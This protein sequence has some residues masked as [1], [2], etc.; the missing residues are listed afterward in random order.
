MRMNTEAFALYL[1]AGA[2]LPTPPTGFIETSEKVFVT[3]NVTTI[4]SKRFNGTLSTN[5]TDVDTC[6]TTVEGLAIPH[7]MRYQNS[8]G[9]ALDTIPDYSEML[10]LGGFAEVVDTTTAGEETVTYNWD[11]SKS[12]SLGSAVYYID[13]YK[14]TFTNTL[15]GNTSFTFNIGEV[16]MINF[17]MS[18]FL[19]NKGI[20]VAEANPATTLSDEGSLFVGCA[21]IYTEDGTRINTKS[22]SIDMGADIGKFYGMGVKEYQLTM[23]KPTI[24]AEFYLEKDDYNKAMTRLVDQETFDVVIKLGTVNGA[25]VNGKTVTFT[26][27]N[28]KMSTFSDADDTNAIS[29]THNLILT[30]NSSFS[31]FHGFY[32]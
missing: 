21:D 27:S 9:D 24:T 16:A 26:I 2:T 4:D 3:P 1:S 18:G 22:I 14:Q 25:D 28:V 5:D 6:N 11:T 17:A 13:G 8:A 19:D 23:F 29:R 7:K 31:I 32:S 20:A 12:P 30:P 10:K 15:A